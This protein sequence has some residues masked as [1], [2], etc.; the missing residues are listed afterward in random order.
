MIIGTDGIPIE[1]KVVRADPNQEAV[2][3]ELTTLLRASLAAASDTG[4]GTLQE[5][6][7]VTE[8]TTTLLVAITPEYFLFASLAR[9]AVVGPGALRAAPGE[10][11]SPA[12]VRVKPGFL[13]TRRSPQI[14]PLLRHTGTFAL[15]GERVD[16]ADLKEILR[17]LEAQD[18][19]EFELEQDGVKLRVCR[20]SKNAP[21]V[22][23]APTALMAV[24]PVAGGPAAAPSAAPLSPPRRRSHVRGGDRGR[25]GA[26]RHDREEPDRGDVLSFSGPELARLS[27]T[28]VTASRWGRCSASSRR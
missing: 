17:I 21:Y 11:R 25:G 8:R 19:T 14:I 15:Q 13:T 18:I 1:K 12:R 2:A 28:W 3:A 23:S 5:L 4:L 27:S 9:G 7:L 26:R 16:I 22:A 20:A 24:A 6:A 10:P